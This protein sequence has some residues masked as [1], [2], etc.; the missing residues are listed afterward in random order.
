[1]QEAYT[2]MTGTLWDKLQSFL[3]EKNRRRR[4]SRA[5]EP[6]DESNELSDFE[7]VEEEAALTALAFIDMFFRSVR[8]SDAKCLAKS[9]CEI[10][11]TVKRLGKLALVMG[12]R[13][14]G[15]AAELLVTH[16]GISPQFL[17]KIYDYGVG[18][19]QCQNLFPSVNSIC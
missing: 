6:S 2:T 13:L 11:R 14:Q 4:S 8:Q 1:M 17:M 7:A 19:G 16:S 15:A 9:F 12:T 3:S 5:R 10:G 18:E